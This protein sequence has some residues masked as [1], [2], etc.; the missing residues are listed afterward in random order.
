MYFIFF[1]KKKYF[2]FVFISKSSIHIKQIKFKSP[3]GITKT[4]TNFLREWHNSLSV[5]V[6][7]QTGSL[8]ANN[9]PSRVNISTARELNTGFEGFYHSLALR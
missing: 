2:G 5:R 7:T 3:W 4:V 8:E 9:P 6:T 1:Y